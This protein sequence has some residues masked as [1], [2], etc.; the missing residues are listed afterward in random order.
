[1]A[2]LAGAGAR[3]RAAVLLCA[4]LWVLQAVRYRDLQATLARLGADHLLLALLCC[5]ANYLALSC[6]DQLAFLY[7]G[8]RIARARIALTA[9][10]AYAVSNSVGFAL[11]YRWFNLGMAPL[12]GLRAS[13][14]SPLWSRLAGFVYRHGESFYKFQGLRAYKE[15]FHPV[16][17]PRYIAYAG[18]KFLPALLADVAALSARGYARIFL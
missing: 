2:R 11:L 13:K 1:M 14:A 10:I 16:W 17:E 5:A 12:S 15:K 3:R 4:A 9:F 7:I 8:K 6:Y 18:G